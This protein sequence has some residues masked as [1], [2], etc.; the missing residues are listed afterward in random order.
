MRAAEATAAEERDGAA[1]NPRPGT[2]GLLFVFFSHVFPHWDFLSCHSSVSSQ[3]HRK[4]RLELRYVEF[5][6]RLRHQ[7]RRESKLLP[8]PHEVRRLGF[9]FPLFRGH[10]LFNVPSRCRFSAILCIGLD[11]A[12]I[13]FLALFVSI[14]IVGFDLLD[15]ASVKQHLLPFPDFEFR[16]LA[17]FLSSSRPRVAQNQLST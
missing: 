16:M 3:L 15:E 8:N 14:Q 2:K 5:R 9:G 17:L 6:R 11:E 4:R 13:F 1:A 7:Q 10:G 12:G